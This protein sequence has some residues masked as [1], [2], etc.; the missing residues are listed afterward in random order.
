[1]GDSEKTRL[2]LKVS[3]K[4]VSIAIGIVT[5][6]IGLRSLRQVIACGEDDETFEHSL[7]HRPAFAFNRYRHLGG[8]TIPDM[9]QLRGVAWNTIKDFVAT[10]LEEHL[11]LKGNNFTTEVKEIC[12]SFTTDLISTIAFGINAN[13][14]TNPNGE[15]RSQCRNM[16]L[17]TLPRAF[18][19]SVAFFLPKLV[20][21]LRVKIFSPEFSKFLRS[22]INHV[23]RERERTQIPRND[24]IDI[25]VALKKEAS[26]EGNKI[27]PK[28]YQD[29]L[30]AQAAVF[31][32]AGFETS[33]STMAFTLFELAKKPELQERLRSEIVNALALE[34]SG[35]LSYENIQ[36][37]NY[38]NMVVEETL[39]LYPVLPFLDRQHQR[40]AG[41]HK[42][43]SLKPYYEYTLPDEMPVYIPIF[44]IQ[45]DPKYWPNPNEFDPERFSP[46]NKKLNN[47]STTYMPFGTGPHNCIGSRIGL[48][49]TKLGL[50]HFLK[51]YRVQT[52]SKTPIQEDFD[53][54]ALVLQFENGVTLNVVRDNLYEKNSK[55]K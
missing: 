34:K 18:D 4:E 19:F 13:S 45:R 7:C 38:L 42:G 10:G 47:N 2:L 15:F 21:L 26:L 32:T 53:P 11:Y 25:L 8:D 9:N 54:K 6:H 50:V 39:R 20:S 30:V 23:M 35:H 27:N 49:Q 14:L 44:A 12:A 3:K 36:S 52:C 28:D 1:M 24:L 5:G 37:L 22:T 55:S 16:F 31:L 33:S 43:F 40:P 51:N 48:L 41:I 17:F 46:E 29:C